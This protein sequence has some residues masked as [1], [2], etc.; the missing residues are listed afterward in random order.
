MYWYGIAMPSEG[1]CIA[2]QSL[3]VGILKYTHNIKDARITNG[4]IV[5]SH[6]P[7]YA[8][9][10]FS[11]HST[12]Y[13]YHMHMGSCIMLVHVLFGVRSVFKTARGGH[14]GAYWS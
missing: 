9:V 12:N 13:R 5:G 7:I 3:V 1:G 4:C 8:R 6:V 10:S 2:L 14:M 11:T